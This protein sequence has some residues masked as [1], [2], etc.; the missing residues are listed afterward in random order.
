MGGDVATAMGWLIAMTNGGVATLSGA[1]YS[2][3]CDDAATME[4]PF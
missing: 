2:V 1:L 4:R 3:V